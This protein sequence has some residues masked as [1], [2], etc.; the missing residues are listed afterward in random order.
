MSHPKDS[1]IVTAQC[2]HWDPHG[3]T[4]SI[5]N[6]ML[7]LLS[8]RGSQGLKKARYGSTTSDGE[9]QPDTHPSKGPGICNGQGN[10]VFGQRVIFPPTV[11]A[12]TGLLWRI[13]SYGTPTSRGEGGREQRP[14][15]VIGWGLEAQ[16]LT[17]KTPANGKEGTKIYGSW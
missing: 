5:V 11:R 13:L 15:M 3:N 10:R 2:P 12:W 16:I 9:A 7:Y 6:T 1:T 4:S 14:A 17:K 8:Y